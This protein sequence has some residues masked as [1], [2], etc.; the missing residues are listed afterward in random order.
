MADKIKLAQFIHFLKPR[1]RDAHKGMSGHVLIVGGAPGFSGAPRMAAEAALRVGAG[2]VSLATHPDQAEMGNLSV[3]E[4]MCHGV[5]TAKQLQELMN[6]ATVVAIGPGLGQTAWARIL[7]KTVL[8]S[9]LPLI[10]DADGLNLLASKP[11]TRD[12]WIFTPH[13]GEAGRLL[14]QTLAVWE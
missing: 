1:P 3:P 7:F 12:H 6:K 2:L 9:S 14:K 8:E 10:V 13:P 4:I 11:Q 5:T